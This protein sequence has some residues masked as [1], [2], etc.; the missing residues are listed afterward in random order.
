MARGAGGGSLRAGG[1]GAPAAAVGIEFGKE[2]ID[3]RCRSVDAE[4]AEAA[5][6]LGARDE[7]IGIR[8]P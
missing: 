1:R 8:I 2:E 7:A 5:G 6:E 3:L 4:S